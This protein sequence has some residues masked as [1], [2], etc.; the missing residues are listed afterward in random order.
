MQYVHTTDDIWSQGTQ[1]P[2]YI[3]Y[4]FDIQNA[5]ISNRSVKEFEDKV[6]PMQPSPDDL[7]LPAHCGRLGWREEGK[8][9]FSPLVTM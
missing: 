8:G 4:P 1:W 3:R 5:F 6:G 7:G 2:S 9:G